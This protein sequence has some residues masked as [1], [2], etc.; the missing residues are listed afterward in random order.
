LRA[1]S[2]FPAGHKDG[3]RG[4]MRVVGWI[5]KFV[6]FVLLVGFAVKNTD[7]VVVRLYLGYEWQSPLV[8]VIL[9]FFAAGA[10]F[11]MLS[12]LPFTFHHRREVRKLRRELQVRPAAPS[13][14]TPPPERAA[15]QTTAD[16]S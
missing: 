8:F 10:V 1:A 15:G 9:V 6:I 4:A 14:S 7:P 5:L 2:L 13:E 12:T 16:I 11:G 3:E